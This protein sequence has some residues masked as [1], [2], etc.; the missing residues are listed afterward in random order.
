MPLDWI[1]TEEIPFNALLLLERVQIGW[2]Q[3]WV[4]EGAL[5]TALHAHPA[6]SWFLRHKRPEFAPWLDRILAQYPPSGD[7]QAVYDAE[8]RVLQ[9]IGD[10]LVY[11]LDPAIYDRLPFLAWDSSELTGLV[12]FT[13]K[14]VLD[15]GAGTGRL[16]FE[17]APTV[18]LVYAVEPVG[19]LRD[20]LR[21]KARH[22]GAEN[23]YVVDGL[24]TAIPFPDGFADVV[25]SGHVYGD[26]PRPERLEL[27]RVTRPGGAIVLMPGNPDQDNPAH[28]ELV[29]HGYRW[30]RFMEPEDGLRRKYWKKR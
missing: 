30:D 14:V 26:D 2:M 20:Y 28:R 8:Q 15:I 9:E 29:E 22:L 19:N 1:S 12:D 7:P 17:A 6:V 3:G 5:A 21:Q 4:T 10:L 25:L 23:F 18:R 11:V 13:D 16:A 27:E 24:I